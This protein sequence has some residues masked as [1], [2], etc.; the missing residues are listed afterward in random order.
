[1]DSADRRYSLEIQVLWGRAFSDISEVA[2]DDG[3][4]YRLSNGIRGG[5]KRYY[6]TGHFA[7]QLDVDVDSINQIFLLLFGDADA[8]TG[9]EILNNIDSEMMTDYGPTSVSQKDPAFSPKGYHNGA[10]WPFTTSVLAACSYRYGRIDLG[11]KCFDIL[12]RRNFGSQC[13]ARINEIFQPDGE[14]K[15]CPS[16]AWSIGLLPYL[17][18]ECVLGIHVDVPKGRIL[19]DEPP[20]DVDIDRKIYVKNREVELRF[21]QGSLWSNAKMERVG[22]SFIVS[23]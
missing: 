19:V 16:Q 18:D 10:I 7:D 14:P 13:T 21:R 23:L 9:K 5:L 15:G 3:A 2:K 4:F 6:R 12:Q 1:M 17:I 22:G 20:M 11:Q 8:Q